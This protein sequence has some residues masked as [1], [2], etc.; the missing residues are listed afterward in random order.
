MNHDPLKL[1]ASI[2]APAMQSPTTSSS[3]S[4][5]LRS[6]YSSGVDMGS[7]TSVNT[8]LHKSKRPQ[9]IAA[10][11]A[12]ENIAQIQ[13]SPTED[14]LKKKAPLAAFQLPKN[15]IPDDAGHIK[16]SPLH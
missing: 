9:R 1:N 2:S 10:T 8:I 14:T 16:V 3:P 4:E 13:R 7:D 15:A 11:K 5:P 6:G 12:A